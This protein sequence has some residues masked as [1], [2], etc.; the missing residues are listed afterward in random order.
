MVDKLA[1]RP[2]IKKIVGL[3][4]Q[5]RDFDSVS[6]L[7]KKQ[8]LDLDGKNRYSTINIKLLTI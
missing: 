3:V 5:N 6:V 4:M 2:S 1:I 8:D 7:D